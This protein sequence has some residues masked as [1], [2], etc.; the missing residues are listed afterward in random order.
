MRRLFLLVFLTIFGLGI[1]LAIGAILM[2]RV[3]RAAAQMRPD[4][5]AGV[6]AT[7]A[8]EWRSRMREAMVVGAEAAAEKEAELR[9]EYDIPTMDE[10]ARRY[11]SGED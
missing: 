10:V 8:T 2:R 7:K 1:G 4:N 5:L 3:D 9:R 11:R 6:A